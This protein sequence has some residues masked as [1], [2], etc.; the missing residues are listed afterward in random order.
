MPSQSFFIEGNDHLGA[1]HVGL[2]GRNQVGLIGVF[3]VVGWVEL[4]EGGSGWGGVRVGR[5]WGGAGSRRV[6]TNNTH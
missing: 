5:G 2:A 1:A 6:R 4:R 3:P